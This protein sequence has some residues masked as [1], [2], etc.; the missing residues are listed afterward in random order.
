MTT[1]ISAILSVSLLLMLLFALTRAFLN[2]YM[3]QVCFT[4]MPT[5]EW[6]SNVNLGHKSPDFTASKK[7]SRSYTLFQVRI[8]SRSLKI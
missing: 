2:A 8:I 6:W 3:P 5:D 1:I 7:Q 4:V